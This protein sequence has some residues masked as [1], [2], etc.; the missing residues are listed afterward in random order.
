VPTI[1]GVPEGDILWKFGGRKRAARDSRTKQEHDDDDEE[2]HF[3]KPPSS[4]YI[5]RRK[6]GEFVSNAKAERPTPY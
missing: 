6:H 2:H 3:R 4:L 5:S 1:R